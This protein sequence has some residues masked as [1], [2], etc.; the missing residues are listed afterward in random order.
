MKKLLVIFLSLFYL[1]L[2][3]GFAQYVYLCKGMA[4]KVY[5]FTNTQEQNQDKPC[6]LCSAKDKD[7]KEKK[8]NC[9]KNEAKLVKVNDSIKKQFNFDFSVKFWGDAIPNKMLGAVF[10]VESI[11]LKTEKNTTYSSSK[12]PI[13]GN[14]LYILHCVYRI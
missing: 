4:S 9:C 12:V 3:S 5:S 6:S 10:D 14:P 2:A 13:Q 11:L 8:K 1:A 7:L